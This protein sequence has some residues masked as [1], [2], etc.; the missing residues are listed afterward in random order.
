VLSKLSGQEARANTELA[1]TSIE[2]ATPDDMVL[3]TCQRTATR[4]RTTFF[5][6]LPSDIGV[7]VGKTLSPR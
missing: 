6:L 5:Y 4:T 7:N 1:S 2:R 3:F